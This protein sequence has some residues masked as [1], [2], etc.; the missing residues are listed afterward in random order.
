ME[1]QIVAGREYE[2]CYELRKLSFFH[3]YRKIIDTV[4]RTLAATAGK[5]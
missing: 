3:V 5:P 2:E 4:T 1:E